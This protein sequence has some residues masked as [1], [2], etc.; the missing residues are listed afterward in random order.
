MYSAV[1][2]IG[3][4]SD[5]YITFCIDIHDEDHGDGGATLKMRTLKDVHFRLVVT[6]E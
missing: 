5:T 6:P 3:M 1:S 2:I 4:N